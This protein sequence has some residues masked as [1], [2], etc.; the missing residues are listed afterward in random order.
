MMFGEGARIIAQSGRKIPPAQLYFRVT[1]SARSSENFS[2][3]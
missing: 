3:R 1:E 2:I